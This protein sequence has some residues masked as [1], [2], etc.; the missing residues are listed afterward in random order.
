M[1]Q[2]GYPEF[3][4]VA[5]E[6][7]RARY[8]L[9]GETP[10]EM[11]RRVA[12]HVAQAE[13]RFGREV[14]G[15]LTAS[16]YCIMR[17]LLFLPNSPTLMNAGTPLG[18]LS[19]CF[20][21]PL[22][23]SLDSI[24]EAVKNA[25]LIQKTGGGV[26]YDFS[27]IR[28]RGDVVNST[29]MAASG[30]I[31]FIKAFDAATEAVNQGGR[32]RGANMAVLRVDHPDIMDFIHA[33]RLDGLLSNFNLSVAVTD[34]FFSAVDQG[35]DFP[36]RNPRTGEVTGRIPAGVLFDAIIESA[37][38]CG[39]PGLLFIDRINIANPTPA[40]GCIQATNPCGEQPLLPWES[41]NLGSINLARM[42]KDG[43]VNW[44]LLAEVVQLGVRFL[45]DV[46][47]VNRFPL[48]QIEQVTLGNRKIGLG[49]MGFAD[50]LINLRI[51]YDSPAA[52]ELA[53]QVMGFIQAEAKKASSLLGRQRGSFPN[54]PKS[55]LARSWSHMRNATVTSIAPTGSISLI[56]GCSQ[57]IEPVFSFVQKRRF[58]GGREV[59]LLHPAMGPELGADNGK[60]QGD[61]SHDLYGIGAGRELRHL[62]GAHDITPHWQIAVQAAFQRH[63]DNG[64]SKT[65]NL[66]AESAISEARETFLQSYARGCKGVT[67]Y[68]DGS[69]KAQVLQ[70]G[71]KDQGHCDRMQVGDNF[72][73][74]VCG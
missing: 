33:K 29:Q 39:E 36:L 34:E 52:V 28:A 45:D 74:E 62:R 21:I 40:L 56:A 22:E 8:L 31:P 70:K 51:P 65:V 46:I 26:G 73:C 60:D 48:P 3:N 10:D 38:E 1:N 17:S 53:D 63:V 9:P 37:W 47:E 16:F 44:V 30:P 58:L 32:R 67:L 71:S 2:T 35:A 72:A 59:V 7:M 57:S 50:L 43:E 15:E 64:V 25:A 24:F 42:V 5:Q 19:A 61:G 12:R 49:V 41:C 54:F 18:Q 27:P 55:I 14:E 69:K 20:V 66:P 4:Q 23:D 68:R 11:F 13:R 6:L